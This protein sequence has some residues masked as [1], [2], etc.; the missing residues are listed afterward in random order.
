MDLLLH[1]HNLYGLIGT[2]KQRPILFWEEPFS[3]LL[4]FQSNPHLPVVLCRAPPCG[5]GT[6]LALTSQYLQQHPVFKGCFCPK[7]TSHHLEKGF[8][9]QPYVIGQ[10]VCRSLQLIC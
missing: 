10:I 3:F 8:L 2:I 7:C 1:T 5:H 9:A 4:V 6:A